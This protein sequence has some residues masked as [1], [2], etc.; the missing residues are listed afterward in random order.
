LLP[1]SNAPPIRII[2]SFHTDVV[3]SHFNW[4][5]L[6]NKAKTN[7]AGVG[8]AARVG[9]V[10]LEIA[11]GK[12]ANSTA[13]QRSASAKDVAQIAQWMQ[14]QM[15]V[16]G[17]T[18]Y[19]AIRPGS[20]E[21]AGFG[22]DQAFAV[23][24][25]S[26]AAPRSGVLSTFIQKLSVYV[27]RGAPVSYWYTPDTRVT[28]HKSIALNIYDETRRS[29]TPDLNFTITALGG[30]INDTAV[31][32]QALTTDLVAATEHAKV[33][34]EAAFT[35][36]NGGKSA[37]KSTPWS[38][39]PLN[40]SRLVITAHGHGEVTVAAGLSFT[41]AQLM[42][43]PSYRG[44]WVERVIQSEK[45]EGNLIASS[46]SEIVTVTVQITS[47]DRL[48]AVMVE[49]LMPGGLE[50]LDPAV[51]PSAGQYY[52]SA[53]MQY[54][55]SMVKARFGYFSPGT[56]VVSFKAT[57][58]TPGTYV[59]PPVKA[60]AENQPELMGLS[61]A[62]MFVVCPAPK[63]LGNAS[64]PLVRDP[65]FGVAPDDAKFAA[66]SGKA[67]ELGSEDTSI[68]GPPPDLCSSPAGGRRPPL[69]PAKDCPKDCSGHGICNLLAGTC[70]CLGDYGG[71][72]CSTYRPDAS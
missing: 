17:R 10:L 56:A 30:K 72:D 31:Q 12:A 39:L 47:A 5:A 26:Q 67:G 11:T 34:M 49:V 27:S 46:F 70:V 8:D 35:P 20:Q 13:Q 38:Q 52:G 18:A 7:E 41:P 71:A 29:T 25:L 60:W 24:F 45:A 4:V 15:R 3:A 16:Q 23:N 61:D 68:F 65:G 63:Q 64:V 22:D 1:L 28:L 43:F 59:L 6:V 19:I 54:A 50:P 37:V 21:P 9:L 55:P 51:F 66:A 44:L 62:G 32:Q 2:I 14:S 53:V 69:A 48:D 40:A 58:N 57:S 33:L 36:Q 42:P